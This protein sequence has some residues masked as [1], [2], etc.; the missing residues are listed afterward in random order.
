M[1]CLFGLIAIGLLSVI[2]IA[3]CSDDNPSAPT[4]VELLVSP[5][6]IEESSVVGI[7][8]QN[9]VLIRVDSE[10]VRES[11]RF[12]FSCDASWIELSNLAGTD[13]GNTTDSFSVMFSVEDLPIGSYTDSVCVTSS[14]ATNSP[15]YIEVNYVVTPQVPHL[16]AFPTWLH[17]Y[18]ETPDQEMDVRTIRVYATD[19]GHYDYTIDQVADW[20]TI[21]GVS[22]ITPDTFDITVDPSIIITGAHVDTLWVH[23]NGLSDSPQSVACSL[24]I[25]PWQLQTSLYENWILYDMDFADDLHGWAVGLIMDDENWSGFI[26][27]TSDG[28]QWEDMLL[29]PAF[30]DQRYGLSA[31]EIVDDEMWIVGQSGIIRYTQNWGETWDSK[32]TGLIDTVVDLQD[33]EL[34]TNQIGWIVGEDGLILKTTD[35]GD[36]WTP[37]NSGAINVLRACS[38]VDENTGWAVGDAM[39]ALRTTDGGENWVTMTGP[40]WDSRDVFFIDASTGWIVG[41]GGNVSF[42]DDGGVSWTEQTTDF[43]GWLYTV[44]FYDQSIGWAAGESGAVL[45]TDDGGTTWTQ[46]TTGTVN[47]IYSVEFRDQLRGRIAGQR[48]EI[49]YTNSGG[50]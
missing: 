45:Y 49:R 28:E 3:A 33:I 43:S 6:T 14:Q 16:R 2:L 48:G 27:K 4:P 23:A 17:Y 47:T 35:G 7:P 41:H 31:L 34:V 30:E 22:G 40:F 26:V 36:T 11:A 42:T 12:T 32:S 5:Q 9:T 46:Q 8:N 25:H 50:N 20:I 21:S 18:A 38:F 13:Y 10:P 44:F 15:Q 1:L 19:D 39:T 24:Y 37:Q 29:T